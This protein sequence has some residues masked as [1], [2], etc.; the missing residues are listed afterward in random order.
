MRSALAARGANVGKLA[1]FD[2]LEGVIGLS[3]IGADLAM[4]EIYEDVTFPDTLAG[5]GGLR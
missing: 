3:S 4:A 5:E 1:Q 2:G